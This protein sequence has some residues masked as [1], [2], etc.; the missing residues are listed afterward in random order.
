M[1]SRASPDLAQTYAAAIEWWREAGVDMDYAEEPAPWLPDPES[2]TA[3][4]APKVERK[5]AA[6]VIPAK[7]RI[8]GDPASWPASL[9]EFAAWWLAE[10]SLAPGGTRIAPGGSA[11]A[12]LMVVVPM[13]EADDTGTLLAG[14]HGKLVANMLR[15][16]QI[17]PD[18]AYLASALPAHLPHADWSGLQA[19]GMGAVLAHHIQ[20]A[21]PRRL[22]VLGNDILPLLGLEKRRGVH[23]VPLSGTAMELLSSLAP[24]NLLANAKAR[25]S[26]WRRWLEW[27][28]NT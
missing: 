3:T 22:L 24:D 26:L 11:K 1:E 6:P 25:A 18:A 5:V 4:P 21:A 9:E 27:T 13:P 20:L 28:E 2:E 14:P 16:M 19:E 7:P 23:Q 15:A 12:E 8:G 10:P 17:A